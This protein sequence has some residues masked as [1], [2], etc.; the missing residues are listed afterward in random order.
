MD[1]NFEELENLLY[2]YGISLRNDDGS[3]RYF[4]DVLVDITNRWEDI[5]EDDQ[6]RI[7]TPFKR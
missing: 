1:N 5:G 7:L 2:D 6:D 3:C 4:F